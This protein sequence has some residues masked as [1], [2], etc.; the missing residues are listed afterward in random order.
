MFD[1]FGQGNLFAQPA[2]EELSPEEHRHR[3]E[4]FLARQQQALEPRPYTGKVQPFYRNGTLVEQEGQYGHLKDISRRQPMF[5]PLR[6]N[7]MQ[8]FRAEAY[9][10]LR[11]TYHQLYRLRPATK[12]S[13]GDCGASSED[14]TTTSSGRSAT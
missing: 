6:L 9:L 13:T 1:L 2:Q 4:E 5:H 10:P 3:H 7:T 12:Q 11:D 14:C 8:R